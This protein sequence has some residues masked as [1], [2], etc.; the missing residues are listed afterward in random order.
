MLYKEDVG[1]EPSVYLEKIMEKK[2]SDIFSKHYS[3]MINDL[4]QIVG[5]T[6]VM[7]VVISNSIRCL[8]DDILEIKGE[9]NA[10]QNDEK[11]DY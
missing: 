1:Q 5:F 9:N 8:E 2:I 3:R 10:V 11:V 6:P 7:K 4:S